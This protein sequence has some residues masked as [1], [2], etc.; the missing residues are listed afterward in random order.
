MIVNFL[1]TN[2][3]LLKL[4]QVLV[5]N[6]LRCCRIHS[7]PRQTLFM[8]KLIGKVKSGLS[9]ELVYFNLL[10]GLKKRIL[11]LGFQGTFT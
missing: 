8:K 11:G 10:N 7:L 9:G 2:S 4:S 1:I 3:Q 5:D 6:S